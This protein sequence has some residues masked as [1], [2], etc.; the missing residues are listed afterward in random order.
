MIPHRIA[1]HS[2]HHAVHQKPVHLEERVRA[3]AK[4]AILQ[5]PIHQ[6]A[7]LLCSPL[8]EA[9]RHH[10]PRFQHVQLNLRLVREHLNLGDELRP[11]RILQHPVETRNR[12]VDGRRTDRTLLNCHQ[13]VRGPLP[14]A[15]LPPF[16][17]ELRPVPVTPGLTRN[18]ADLFRRHNS[19]HARQRLLQDRELRLQLSLVR[20]VLVMASTTDPEVRARRGHTVSRR[21]HHLSQRGAHHAATNLARRNLHLFPRQHK[22]RQHHLALGA[23]QAI[24]AI[25]QLLDC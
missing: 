17:M 20:G 14:I 25:D 21:R 2:F 13:L 1:D 5:R 4:P 15:K 12:P 19:T 23:A 7:Q 24:A 11:S 8:E 18:H 16:D 22:G 3:H 9:L 10:L 6:R